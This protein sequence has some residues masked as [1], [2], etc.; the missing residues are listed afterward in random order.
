MTDLLQLEDVEMAFGGLRV[1]QG[2][3]FTLRAGDRVG[4]IGP[5]G[6]GKTTLVNLVTGNL[7]PTAGR[8]LFTNEDITHSGIAHRVRQGLVR[9]F[10]IT[11]LFRTLTVADNVALPVLQRRGLAG[12]FLS[13]ATERPDVRSEW[14]EI[15][16]PVGLEKR[17]YDP[18]DV[19]AYGEQRLVEIA[20]ALALKPK[21]LLLDEPAAGVPHEES[22]RV[23]DAISALPRDIAILMIEHDIDL[24][25]RFADRVLVLADGALIFD[26]P[27]TEAAGDA[28]VR[29]AYL[30]SYADASRPA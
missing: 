9:T 12:R 25:F 7:R 8:I 2:V 18:I 27:P 19:L 1:T 21:V 22:H 24:V 11:R 14:M 16:R 28:R 5:N 15:L 6:A 17:A 30:G 29:S 4:L 13:S 20:I 3:S 10:Q 26:G 23:L